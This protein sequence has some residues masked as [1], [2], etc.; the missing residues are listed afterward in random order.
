M[1][2]PRLFDPIAFLAIGFWVISFLIDL[3]L[4]LVWLVIPVALLL[5]GGYWLLNGLGG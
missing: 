4:W 2:E 1:N 5:G 3:V